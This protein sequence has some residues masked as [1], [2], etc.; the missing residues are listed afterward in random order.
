MLR[1]INLALYVG[2]AVPLPVSQEVIEA[3]T[4]VRVDT[5]SDKPAAFE[6]KFTLSNR[7]SLVQTLF[8]DHYSVRAAA[9]RSTSAQR[10]AP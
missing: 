7:A 4:D 10:R 9:A 6:L 3:L 8:P 2:P 5:F 1:N